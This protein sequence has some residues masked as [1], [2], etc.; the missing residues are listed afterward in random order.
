M[1]DY[2][3]E[4][5][6]LNAMMKETA[7]SE[8]PK[9]QYLVFCLAAE[10]YGID[11]LRVQEIQRWQGVTLMPNTPDFVCG[12]MN[13]RGTII[14]LVDLRIRFDMAPKPHTPTTVVI[15]LTVKVKDQKTPKIR[16]IVVDSVFDTYDINL[17]EIKPGPDFGESVDTAHISGLVT[18]S[19]KMTML[20]D[21]DLLLATEAL[22]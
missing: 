21:I 4:R 8:Q 3:I 6:Q 17:N 11:I 7:A 13:L 5:Q 20:L 9:K 12:V 2:P 22:A 16:A 14:P 19:G 1:T 18:L 15:V 10:K